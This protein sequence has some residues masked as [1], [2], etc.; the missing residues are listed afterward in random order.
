MLQIG[1]VATNANRCGESSIRGGNRPL[2][3]HGGMA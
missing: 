3:P 2:L 1:W